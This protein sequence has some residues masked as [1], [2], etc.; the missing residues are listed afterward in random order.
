M[1]AK[2]KPNKRK[3]LKVLADRNAWKQVPQEVRKQGKANSG[4]AGNDR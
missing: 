2:R 4:G 3:M 1:M